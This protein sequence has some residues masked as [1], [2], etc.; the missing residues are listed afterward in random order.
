MGAHDTV[1]GFLSPEAPPKPHLPVYCSGDN[2]K[3]ASG[4][5]GEANGGDIRGRAQ[6]KQ[7]SSS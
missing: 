5:S 4:V 1:G 7:E 6:G 3:L 2:S